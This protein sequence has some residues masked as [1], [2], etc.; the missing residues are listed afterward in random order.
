MGN[1]AVSYGD[2]LA[3]YGFGGSHPWSTD[4]IHAFWRRLSSESVDN[5][6]VDGPEIATEMPFCCFMTD[7]T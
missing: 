5:L 6:V 1:T 3:R 4:R 7:N 2:E